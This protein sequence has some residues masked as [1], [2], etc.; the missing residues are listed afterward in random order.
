MKKH[1]ITIAAGMLLLVL[2]F[3]SN[4]QI[5]NPGFEQWTA[6]QP[7]DWFT[8]NIQGI[9][10]P[11]T[12]SSTSHS[13]SSALRGEVVMATSMPYTPSLFAGAD[14]NGFAVSQRYAAV[15]GYYQFAP[16]SGDKFTVTVTMWR[17]NMGI[18][19]GILYISE[20]SAVYKPFTVNITY[21][22]EEVPDNCMIQVLITGPATG[23]DFHLGSV[24]LLD[25]LSF[26]S[27]TAIANDENIISQIPEQF[28][29]AQNYPNP[30]NATTKIAYDLPDAGF[31][32]L[33]VLD[34]SGREIATLMNGYS[35]AGHHTVTFDAGKLPSGI[36]F[37]RLQT[38]GYSNVKKLILL[39]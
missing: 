30:F 33:K 28:N 39:K 34:I 20:A 5:P 8:T 6:G 3:F 29:L 35:G 12:Q 37:Y 32:S 2:P 19:S 36:Y 21:Y 18:G 4:A 16:V 14:A 23:D 25:D 1:V 15:S 24:M 27:A 13:G 22:T 10:V 26:S 11:I 31:V 9:A 7:A 17:D 38:D